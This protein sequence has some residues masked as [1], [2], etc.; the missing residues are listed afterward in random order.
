[1]APDG[2]WSVHPDGSAEFST[3]AEEQSPRLQG[4]DKPQTNMRIASMGIVLFIL[5]P[6]FRV[7]LMLFCLHP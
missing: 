4:R 6:S 2:Y 3:D 7:L 1:V 5:L